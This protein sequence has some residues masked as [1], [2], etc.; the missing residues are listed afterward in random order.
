MDGGVGSH[1]GEIALGV[2]LI[3]RGGRGCRVTPSAN[4]T[5]DLDLFALFF[6][7]AYARGVWAGGLFDGYFGWYAGWGWIAALRSQ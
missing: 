4:P 7:A 6:I 2:L 1:G 3:W 5:Y